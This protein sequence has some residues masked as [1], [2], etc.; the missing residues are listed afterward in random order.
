MSGSGGTVYDPEPPKVACDRLVFRTVVNSPQPEIL[1]T[2]VAEEILEVSVD[3][4]G[5]IQVLTVKKNKKI[6]GTLTSDQV[7]VLIACMAKGFKYQAKVMSKRGGR[8]EVE[9]SH[10]P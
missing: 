7:S 5:G 4:I 1:D 8:C 9:V 3:L 6:V 2:V 10:K